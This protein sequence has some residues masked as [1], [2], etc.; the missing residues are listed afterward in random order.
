MKILEYMAENIILQQV[1]INGMQFWLH[2]GHSTTDAIFI[3]WQLQETF[4]AI[5]KSF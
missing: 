3:I 4:F 1:R 5:N 2:T